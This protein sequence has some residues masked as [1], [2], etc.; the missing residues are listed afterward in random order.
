[1]R[2]NL[3]LKEWKKA[4]P[5][6]TELTPIQQQKLAIYAAIRRRGMIRSY[7]TR[8]I[9]A[10]GGYTARAI[11]DYGE[12]AAI[13]ISKHGKPAAFEIYAHG[14]DGG[15]VARAIS[16]CGKPAI[17]M[18]SKHGVK[19]AM[20]IDSYGPFALKA[21]SKHGQPAIYAMLVDRKPA[22]RIYASA[23]DL[24]TARRQLGDYLA[25]HKK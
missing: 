19:A 10:E 16:K 18:I 13:A 9:A 25:T 8:V 12:P 5:A 4:G 24:P 15:Y 21:I 3:T 20:V 6:I 23:P 22:A 1:M 14:M 17:D 7:A 2:F 11:A